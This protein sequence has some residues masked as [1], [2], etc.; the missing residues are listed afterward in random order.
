MAHSPFVQAL[1]PPDFARCYGCGVDNTHGHHLETRR[2]G[3]ST[4]TRFTPEP[5]HTG[6]S[7]FAYG[8]LIASMID[9]HSAGSAAIFWMIANE[10]WQGA[11]VAPRFVTARLEVNYLKPTPLEPIEL[12]SSAPELGERKVVVATE[13]SV[14]KLVT[15]TGRAVLV[16]VPDGNIGRIS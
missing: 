13:L 12:R 4:V 11:T 10:N 16:K 3:V 9:C 1:Y 7:D 14:G 2:D 5:C 8:G 6:A 15:A